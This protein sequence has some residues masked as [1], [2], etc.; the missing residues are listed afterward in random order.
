MQDHIEQC[1]KLPV[2]C[3]NGCGAIICRETIPNHTED[4]CLL[5]IM[6]CP[7]EEMGCKTKVQRREVESHLHYAMRLHLDLACLK[8]N[9][10]EVKLNDMQKTTR[11]L[12]EKIHKLEEKISD[13]KRNEAEIEKMVVKH[14]L[15]GLARVI[16]WKIIN[17][18]EIF[19]QAKTGEIKKL[20]GAPFYTESYGYKLKVRIYPN[21]YGTYTNTHLMVFIILMKGEYDAILP[22]PFKR[23]VTYTLIDQQEDPAER[24]NVIGQINYDNRPKYFE[25]PIHHEE[26]PGQGIARFISH[27]KLFSRRYLVDDTLFLQ[28]EVGP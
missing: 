19:R 10:T 12:M 17:F 11:E 2:T 18:S 28:V 14:E 9:T 25:R 16:V 6:P 8:L 24:E 20:D 3:P 5:T 7:Y 1:S 22:W 27:E 13:G 23:K 26:N 15:S 4:D 21:G